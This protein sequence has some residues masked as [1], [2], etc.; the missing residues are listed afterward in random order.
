MFKKLRKYV[1]KVNYGLLT[2]PKVNFVENVAD[3]KLHPSN[4]YYENHGKLMEI[5]DYIESHMYGITVQVSG[6]EKIHSD[7]EDYNRRPIVIRT[8]KH[9]DPYTYNKVK[10]DGIFMDERDGAMR[11][12]D[13]YIGFFIEG[14]KFIETGTISLWESFIT[15]WLDDN[16]FNEQGYYCSDNQLFKFSDEGCELII[17]DVAKEVIGVVETKIDSVDLEYD[18]DLVII[19]HNKQI[20]IGYEKYYV[21]KTKY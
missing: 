6:G 15:Q 11:V 3:Y 10:I 17:A 7:N 8:F 20:L 5:K 18:M 9:N 1:E 14:S 19:C 2:A 21:M 16:Y 4:N 12:Y 13:N